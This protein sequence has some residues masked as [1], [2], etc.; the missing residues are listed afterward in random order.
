MT[1]FEFF[2]A[3]QKVSQHLMGTRT[4]HTGS[5]TQYFGSNYKLTSRE[6]QNFR[7]SVFVW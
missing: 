5:D 2:E 4:K 6:V 1:N 3:S 7:L